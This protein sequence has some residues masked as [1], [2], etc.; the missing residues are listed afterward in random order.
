M[1]LLSTGGRLLKCKMLRHSD[2]FNMTDG[3][4]L[5]IFLAIPCLRTESQSNVTISDS[6]IHVHVCLIVAPYSEAALFEF[7]PKF[8]Q[9][10]FN[11]VFFRLVLDACLL[12]LEQNL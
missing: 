10:C 12:L 3:I 6:R 5:M 7:R 9:I 8:G 4:K 1:H 2:I 11:G